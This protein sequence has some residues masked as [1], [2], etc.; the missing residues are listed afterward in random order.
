MAPTC[1]GSSN[2]AYL[3]QREVFID[4]LL[5]QTNFVIVMIRWTGLAL[6][7]FVFPFPGSLTSTFLDYDHDH[8]GEIYRPV[9]DSGSWE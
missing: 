1:A 5:V 6:L 7:E 8:V 2:A 3:D 9:Q 4:N